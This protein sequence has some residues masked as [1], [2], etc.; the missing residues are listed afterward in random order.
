MNLRLLSIVNI[1]WMIKYTTGV[2]IIIWRVYAWLKCIR[3]FCPTDLYLHAAWTRIV[4]ISRSNQCRIVD[5]QIEKESKAAFVVDHGRREKISKQK[6]VREPEKETA[7]HGLKKGR[8]PSVQFSSRRLKGKTISTIK[9]GCGLT[10]PTSLSVTQFKPL[11]CAAA[12]LLLSTHSLNSHSFISV[13]NKEWIKWWMMDSSF[14]GH[15][16]PHSDI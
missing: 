6:G 13:K 15:N 11:N 5:Q 4:L 8:L 1:G 14:W 7:S 16:V 12:I 3:H 2:T 10:E 9:A